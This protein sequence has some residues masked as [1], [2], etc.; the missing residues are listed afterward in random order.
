[1]LRSRAS[2]LVLLLAALTPASALALEPVATFDP[3]AGELPESIAI[4]KRGNVYLSMSNTVRKLDRDGE[5]T[6]FGT[7][8]ISAFALGVKIGPDGC[9]YTASTSLDPAVVGAFVW[10]ICSAGQVEEFAALDPNS[11]PN[12][13]AFDLRGNVYVTDPFL[14]RIYQI[15][16]NG[17]AEVWLSH[18][19]L[20]GDPEQPALIFRHFGA[21]G[22]AFDKHERNLYV[23]NLDAG[24][25]VRIAL[26]CNRE[27]ASV[28]VFASDPLLVGA[29]GLAF[30]TKGN[31]VVAVNAGER[32]VLVDPHGEVTVLAEGGL[33]DSPSSLAFGTFGNDKRTLY[34]TS[35]A[36]SR[37]FGLK[38]GTPIPA[39]LSTPMPHKGLRLP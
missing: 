12:D 21:N 30:D 17:E 7:L 26:D 18:P 9:V 16:E 24:R 8:P 23:G 20:E 10:R 14:G 15:D 27:P 33:L 13:L 28:D 39:L 19:L 2:M 4:D 22:I 29:D 6:V 11:G 3:A 37:A 1:M 31:L 25:I 36:V 34:V 35:S 38:P 5:I 32:L